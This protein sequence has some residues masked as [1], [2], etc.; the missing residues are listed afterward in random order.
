MHRLLAVAAVLALCPL[1]AHAQ[2]LGELGAAMAVHD[3]AAGASMSSG[4][5][6]RYVG[7]KI[8][9]GLSSAS[10]G[11]KSG[12]SSGSMGASGKGWQ[13]SSRSERHSASSAWA[14]AGSSAGSA[15][16]GARTGSGWATASA[17][18]GWVRRDS[19]SQRTR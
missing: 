1:A 9:S 10:T 6:A 19:P 8:K 7:D 17:G 4:S 2:S 13:T 14:S 18:G 16:S 11:A 3:A 12:L 15:R 5:T